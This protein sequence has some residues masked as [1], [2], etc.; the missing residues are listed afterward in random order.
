MLEQPAA[1]DR[2]VLVAVVICFPTS[3]CAL[4]RC[5]VCD[6][7]PLKRVVTMPPAYTRVQNAPTTAPERVVCVALSQIPSAE[8]KSMA[9]TLE[10]ASTI[11][12]AK[13]GM[14][15]CMSPSAVSRRHAQS[16]AAGG[17]ARATSTLL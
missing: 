6:S 8:A 9:A 5:S 10:H 7:T 17:L 1:E 4:E 12:L 15:C 16:C 14:L 3:C 11:A 2:R 13:A